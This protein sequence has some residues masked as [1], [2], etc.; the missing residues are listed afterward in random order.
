MAGACCFSGMRI[1]TAG[2]VQ[3]E[4]HRRSPSL[5]ASSWPSASEL[6]VAVPMCACHGCALSQLGSYDGP[7]AGR[8]R[9][10]QW[11]MMFVIDR[12]EP[13]PAMMFVIAETGYR[14]LPPAPAIGEPGKGAG[15]EGRDP[16]RRRCPA[17]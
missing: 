16:V 9:C 1:L 7:C 12:P 5:A 14:H 3:R 13:L 17:N 2:C 4:V 11:T 10:R 15:A 6:F 8:C